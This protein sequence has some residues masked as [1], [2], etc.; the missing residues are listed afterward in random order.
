VTKQGGLIADHDGSGSERGQGCEI[1]LEVAFAAGTEHVY[2]Q[3][4]AARGFL[5]ISRPICFTASPWW[6]LNQMRS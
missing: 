3:T 5:R 6:D 2:L 4:V 1:R